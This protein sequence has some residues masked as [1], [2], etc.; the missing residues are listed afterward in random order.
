MF[1][2]LVA[3]P[4]I[5]LFGYCVSVVSEL[6]LEK[7][8]FCI[9]TEPRKKDRVKDSKRYV[10]LLARYDKNRDGVISLKELISAGLDLDKE[11]SSSIRTQDEIATEIEALFKIC[12]EDK[13][14]TLDRDQAFGL[15]NLIV[16]RRE[17]ERKKKEARMYLALLVFYT[18]IIIFICAGLWALLEPDW[19]FLNA[20]YYSVISLSTV[21]LGDMTSSSDQNGSVVF[22][23]FF[24]FLGLG[25]VASLIS[26]LTEL[27]GAMLSLR[28]LSD[29]NH[30]EMKEKAEKAEAK[31]N[32]SNVGGWRG[33]EKTKGQGKN[34]VVPIEGD[35]EKGEMGTLGETGGQT[36]GEVNERT[37]MAGTGEPTD[38]EGE[39]KAVESLS[40]VN[41]N[42]VNE[43]I[44]DDFN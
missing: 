39:L 44:G 26:S 10:K 35:P 5:A 30:D 2:A 41:P 31:N 21:G 20:V 6:V 42:K 28:E 8:T 37:A 11:F 18:I 33:M 13:T 4:S 12:D 27:S 17:A 43:I 19:T 22:W 16:Q 7:L 23:Y 9:K 24:T 1:V 15:F 34:A 38:T 36:G 14:G 3:V 40:K 25:I 32:T 29:E